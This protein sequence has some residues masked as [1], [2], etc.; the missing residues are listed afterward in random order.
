VSATAPHSDY[1]EAAGI[2]LIEVAKALARRWKLLVSGPLAAGVCAFGLASLLTPTFTART[3]LLPPQQQ[4]SSAAA[5]LSQLGALAALTGGAAVLKAPGDQY[6]A[7]LQSMTVADRI[8][9]EFNLI[10]VYES[11]FR[12]DA[13]KELGSN[14]RIAAGKRDGL[15]TIEVDDHDPKRAAA[16]ANA[17]VEAIRQ[18][19]SNLA[20]TE[21]QQR[22]VFFEQHLQR[23]KADLIS[24]QVALQASGINEGTL[25]TEPQTAAAGYARLLAEA[26]AAEV[27]LQ[28]LKGMVS[29]TSPEFTH[30]R[31]TV[32]ALRAQINRA[33]QRDNVRGDSGYVA[34]YREFKYREALFD[35]FARQYELAKVDESREGVLIQVLD[36]A[37]PPERKSKPQRA[38]IATSAAISVAVILSMIIIVV[39]QIHKRKFSA[40]S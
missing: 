10:D 13:R 29:E 21:A 18:V 34:K 32:A 22:R 30:Q 23:A 9:D 3:T 17:Y 33:E 12:Q 7:I 4:Q 16:M 24:A 8:I 15:I 36:P 19:T 5:A 2:D 39:S 14:V 11:K 31:A 1:D 35:L 38:L 26:T 27:Q 6:V 40:L 28:V 20:V 25:K 37:T